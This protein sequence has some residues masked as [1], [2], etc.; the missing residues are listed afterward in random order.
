MDETLPQ[1]LLMTARRE[2]WV[3]IDS[4]DVTRRIQEKRKTSG[5]TFT[6]IAVNITKHKY[7]ESSSRKMVHYWI[8]KGAMPAEY[9][10]E[11]EKVMEADFTDAPVSKLDALSRTPII[12]E[13][14]ARMYQ[15]LA[16]A[17]V[18]QAANDYKDARK[19]MARK[20][21]EERKANQFKNDIYQCEQFFLSDWF[22]TLMPNTDGEGFLRLLQQRTRT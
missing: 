15:E 14:P 17:I 3:L 5:L 6:Q 9:L 22:N 10:L 12:H 2:D 19:G 8:T 13:F 21:V 20:N 1:E 16:V 18:R 7:E 11:F 4:E